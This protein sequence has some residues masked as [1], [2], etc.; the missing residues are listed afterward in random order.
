MKKILA[1]AWKDTLVR[2]ASRPF[3][4]TGC[5]KPKL[6]RHGFETL[7]DRATGLLGKRD[8][9]ASLGTIG[10]TMWLARTIRAEM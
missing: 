1:I 3:Q 7:I 10:Q 6:G 4:W 2:F 5:F 9:G 8:K